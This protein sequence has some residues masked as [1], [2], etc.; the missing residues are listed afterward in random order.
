[1]HK[2]F[3]QKNIE[4]SSQQNCVYNETYHILKR[5]KISIPEYVKWILGV[6]SFIHSRLATQH[7]KFKTDTCNKT[8]SFENNFQVEVMTISFHY[9]HM[10][11]II[12]VSQSHTKCYHSFHLEQNM[13]V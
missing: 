8:S 4:L 5:Q 6:Y 11:K 2:L 12:Q 10:K 3:E 7:L 9:T 1:M 13:H